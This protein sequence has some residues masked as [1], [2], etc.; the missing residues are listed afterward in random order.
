MMKKNKLL[1]FAFIIVIIG[2]IGYGAFL[3]YKNINLFT[4]SF[5]SDGYAIYLDEKS[6]ANVLP[7][8]KGTDYSYKKY[9][10]RISFTSSNDNVKVDDSTIIHYQNKNLLLL[11]NT[12]GIDLDNIDQNIVFYYNI[13]K[14]TEINY[15]NNRYEIETINT[16]K[17]SFGKLLLRVNN[18]KFLL[19]GENIK[20]LFATDDIVEFSDYL[21][22]EYSSGSVL[23]IY[24]ADKYHQ[25]IDDTKIIIGDIVINL[26]DK[27]I[28]KNNKKYITLSNLII[29]ND[30]NIDV[31]TEEAK[32]ENINIKKP[33]IDK[34]IIDGTNINPG[35]NSG[36]N[37]GNSDIEETVDEKKVLSPPEFKVTSLELTAL[38][39]DATIEISDPDA[40]LVGD[41]NISIVENATSKIIYE[42]PLSDGNLYAS[43]SYPNLKPDTEYTLYAKGSYKIDDITYD[44]SFVSKIFRTESLGVMFTKSYVTNNS[45][46]IDVVKEKYSKVNS[47]T[48]GIYDEENKLLD[49]K[50]LNFNTGNKYE[51]VFNELEHNKKYLVI[52]YD[53]LSSGLIVD[54]GY[55]QKENIMTLKNA[56]KISGLTYSI[57]KID[58]SF[59]LDASKVIDED[60]GVTGYRYEVFDARSDIS[61]AT[62]LLVLTKDSLGPVNVKVDE[63]K[64]HRGV[65][66]TYRLVTEFFDNEKNV[67][68]IDNLGTIMQIDGVAFPTLRFEPSNI[69]WEQING[70]IVID[71]P[72]G[73]IM[74]DTYKIV[75]KN[76]IDYYKSEM[77]TAETPKNSIPINVRYLRANETY[78]FDVYASINLQDSNETADETYIGSVKVQTGMPKNLQANFKLNNTLSD[79]FSID[80]NL[81]SEDE[82]ASF[83]ASTLSSLT[84]TL[85]QGT[86][87]NGK[88]E[89]YKKVVDTNQDEYTSTLKSMYFDTSKVI[90]ANFFNSENS[91]FKQKNYTLVVD[92]AYDYTGYDSNKINI[93]NNVFNIEMKDYIPSLPNLD[94]SQIIVNQI[95]NKFS[96]SFEIPYNDELDANTI[97][98]YSVSAKYDNSTENAKYILYHVYRYNHLTNEYELLENLD[99]KV[100]FN[101]DGTI[102]DTIFL[103]DNG[104]RYDVVDSDKLRRGNSYYF[105]YEVYIDL[106]NDGNAETIF[107]KSIDENAVLKSD[108]IKPKKQEAIFS[109][110]PS[111]SNSN[112]FTWKYLV[113][114]V[115]YV[116]ADNKLYGFIN[117]SLEPS[118][119]PTIIPNV[120]EY[121]AVTFS[122]LVQG[123]NLTISKNERFI[124]NSDL[125]TSSLT[126]QYFYGMIDNAS[127]S[128]TI[129]AQDNKMSIV[130][131]NLNVN[132]NS[133]ANI[134]VVIEPVNQADKERLGSKTIRGSHFSS[135]EIVVDY[136]DI[137]Q[138]IGV[139]INVSLV[140]YFDNGITGFDNVSGYSLLQNATYDDVGYYYSFQGTRILP[141]GSAYGN[142]ANM[143]FDA[144]NKNINFVTFNGVRNVLNLK[145][146]QTGVM[147]ENN[148]I[149]MKNVK[150]NTI[151]SN[152]STFKFDYIVPGVSV[153]KS[154]NKLN[155]TPLIESVYIDAKII[156]SGTNEIRDN[157][158]YIDVFETDL[159]GSNSNLIKTITKDVSEFSE[160]IQVNGL[161]PKTNYY[162]IMYTYL[163]NNETGSYEK[164][165]LYDV[166]QKVSGVMY[167]FH[168]LSDVGIS[169][170]NV[171]LATTTYRQKTLNI[172]YSLEN[173]SGFNYIE[174]TIYKFEN[175]EYVLSDISLPNSTA[176]F[177]KMHLSLDAAP[178]R[179]KDLTYGGRYKIKMRPVG[180]YTLDDEEFELELGTVEQE[181]VVMDYENPFIG[182]TSGKTDNSIYFRVSI[183]DS[184]N[185]IVDNKY[186]AKLLDSKDNVIAIINDVSIFGANRK[187]EFDESEYNLINNETYTF[188]VETN[189]DYNNDG[190]TH[191]K[192]SKM[193]YYEY[194]SDLDIGTVVLTRNTTG[195]NMIDMIFSDSY[196]I[197]D[198]D[199]ITYTITS[200]NSG[201][202][203]SRTDSFVARYDSNNDLYYYTINVDDDNYN[204]DVVYLVTANF[205]SDDELVESIELDYYAGGNENEA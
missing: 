174:Y 57:S 155:I 93:V 48:L 20:V 82:D 78:T 126:A 127:L 154:N 195:K 204:P 191:T 125:V 65:A 37:E 198:V 167:N 160:H 30:D 35:T 147:Y 16:D 12:V 44:R 90:D 201:F 25:T 124:K 61:K 8:S 196:K 94:E 81:S 45:I 10:N 172:D 131:N 108:V 62:P 99:K 151:T 157:K 9:D 156:D 77:I 11:K 106:D 120:E 130:L 138:Y 177:K 19:A 148:S 115:D 91:D 21:Y 3:V 92:E 164:K 73:T 175:D 68:Y 43:V 168:T 149:I 128:Y 38:K 96:D 109:L 107:P 114:D 85:Y 104:T 23:R 5:T 88:V 162:F 197:D 26:K 58:S 112:S 159:N 31:I 22:F 33:N 132:Y 66:Y 137:K 145:I 60:Y 105:T 72:S 47:V 97:I 150:S 192:I 2:V 49:Y 181:F 122:N 179:N 36:I 143:S 110:Y 153:I 27:T 121:Q 203:Y 144:L 39:V 6:K 165:N 76:S 87:T 1:Y 70:A 53:I 18:N 173:V 89:V 79:A 95:L 63:N 55:N 193:K 169:D 123:N 142:L 119:T 50:E 200:V 190:I 84:F 141:A 117:S 140:V 14:N 134:D 103:L 161:K 133:I 184:T 34:D 41:V 7:F 194:G 180:I 17:V 42:M 152:N 40:T 52:M 71:D 32:T 111:S 199:K 166:D 59:E 75:Y 13:F 80:F 129:N 51:V 182:I 146:N 186:D 158:I 189:V 116:L 170:I 205:Y 113:K 188:I 4:K 28:E 183:N 86:T 83:E 98:G 64:I 163:Y 67:E 118:S 135:S 171:E 100:F 178:G 176:F 69:T 24:N 136:I 187:F 46:V 139:E 15:N 74:S 29:D 185:I 202:Y 56:P 102:N 101:Q 54:D